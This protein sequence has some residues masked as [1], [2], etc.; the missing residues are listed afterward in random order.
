MYIYSLREFGES[1][2]DKYLEALC[3]I[4]ETLSRNREMGL[5]PDFDA[6]DTVRKFPAL[7]HVIY[8]SIAPAEI[9]IRRIFHGS[10]EVDDLDISRFE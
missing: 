1:V 8:Y 2:A 10:R 9:E 5:R 6:P 7:K 3:D 4:F